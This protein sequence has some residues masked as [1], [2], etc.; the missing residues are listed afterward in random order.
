[1]FPLNINLLYIKDMSKETKDS[2]AVRQHMEAAANAAEECLI[3]TDSDILEGYYVGKRKEIY[4]RYFCI[5]KKEAEAFLALMQ[6]R[7]LRKA[8]VGDWVNFNDISYSIYAEKG[9]L[10]E[11]SAFAV[12]RVLSFPTKEMADDFLNCFKDLCETAKILL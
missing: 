12:D 7:Q 9:V 11:V 6:L 2:M 4:D 1:M 8:W 5:N 10:L 3:D